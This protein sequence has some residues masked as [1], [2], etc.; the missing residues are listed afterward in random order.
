MHENASSIKTLVNKYFVFANAVDKP[1]SR[2]GYALTYSLT[3]AMSTPFL[4][5]GF[6]CSLFSITFISIIM[7]T[8]LCF[9]LLETR[10]EK[11]AERKTLF[12]VDATGM[13]NRLSH[14]MDANVLDLTF[15]CIF[16][17]AM[18]EVKYLRT[19]EGMARK[20]ALAI[21]EHFTTR[22]HA[23]GTYPF[24]KIPLSET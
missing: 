6:P 7:T 4:T 2:K 1:L 5:L 23:V 17:D 3:L 16:C 13:T 10:F 19:N 22:H 8:L 12:L 11:R 21:T 18:L 9:M 15:N 24:F 20:Y 14:A